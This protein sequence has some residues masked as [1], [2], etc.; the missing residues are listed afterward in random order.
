MSVFGTIKTFEKWVAGGGEARAGLAPGSMTPLHTSIHRL[1]A[2]AAE[3][4]EELRGISSRWQRLGN[5][6]PV[7]IQLFYAKAMLADLHTL[8]DLT[9]SSVREAMHLRTEAIAAR[10]DLRSQYKLHEQRL[11]DLQE[12]ADQAEREIAK[13][14]RDI[15]AAKKNLTAGQAIKG[16]FEEVFSGGRKNSYKETIIRLR[17]AAAGIRANR[18]R[19]RMSTDNIQVCQRELKQSLHAIDVLAQVDTQM[20]KYQNVVQ[21]CIDNVGQLEDQLGSAAHSENEKVID[22]FT[23][24]MRDGMS[25]LLSWQDTF[26]DLTNQ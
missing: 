13:L 10:R 22:Y 18:H 11:H 16:A 17:K 3:M 26:R 25:E 5:G 21:A 9:A 20:S 8:D 23:D 12:M 24:Q 7:R 4:L 2:E 14:R 19:I 1:K 15:E 6:D